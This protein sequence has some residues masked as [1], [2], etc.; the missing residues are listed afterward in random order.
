MGQV[1][2][3]TT[4]VVGMN[5]LKCGETNELQIDFAP[6]QPLQPGARQLPN[7]P[8]MPCRKCGNSLDL[9][10]VRTQVEAQLG[11]KALSPQP[12]R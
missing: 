5:C 8:T 7:S 12:Q 11:K 3:A 10:A 1:K 4:L 9:L 2:H 6:G